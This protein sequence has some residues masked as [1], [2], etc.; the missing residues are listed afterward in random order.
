MTHKT[1]IYDT[2]YVFCNSTSTC[3]LFLKSRVIVF[4]TNKHAQCRTF[5]SET[6]HTEQMQ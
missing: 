6:L 2:L 1:T 3:I 4:A 5:H